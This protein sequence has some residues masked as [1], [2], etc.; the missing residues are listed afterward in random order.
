MDFDEV[1]LRSSFLK[2]FQ[3]GIGMWI[4][5]NLVHW[6]LTIGEYLFTKTRTSVILGVSCPKFK[7]F[8]C[9]AMSGK[10]HCY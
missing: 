6:V 2:K 10:Q 9:M 1:E 4:Y 5:E 8:L 3:K 7:N